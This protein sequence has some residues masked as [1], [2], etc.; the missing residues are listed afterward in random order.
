MNILQAMDDPAVF[1]AHFR[2]QAHWQAWR[3]F[4]AALFGLNGD[5]GIET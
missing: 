4:L 1:G 3:A 5:S 2:T